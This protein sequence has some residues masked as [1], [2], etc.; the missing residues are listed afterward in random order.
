MALAKI[1]VEYDGT[2]YH[3][4]HK[5]LNNNVQTIQSVIES[6][7]QN[8]FDG[9]DVKIDFCGRT[10]TGVHAIGQVCHFRVPEKYERIFMDTPNKLA[11]AINFYLIKLTIIKMA[12]NNT[13]NSLH[14]R[15]NSSNRKYL[16]KIILSIISVLSNSKD[17]LKCRKLFKLLIKV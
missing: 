5:I 15:S 6:N 12:F 10:D 4:M 7:L 8:V 1:I 17:E 2:Y 3:G 11:L 16:T 9:T 13:R 14:G